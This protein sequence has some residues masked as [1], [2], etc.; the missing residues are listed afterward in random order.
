MFSS[1]KTA[2]P[3]SGYNLTK[4][5]RFRSSASA[6]LSRTLGTATD[7]KKWTFSCWVKGNFSN[8]TAYTHLFGT[9]SGSSDTTSNQLLWTTNGVSNF[10]F[11]LWT[12]NV[13]ITNAAYRDPSA[14]YHVMV[15]M[16]NANANATDRAHIYINGVEPTYSTDNRASLSTSTNYAINSSILHTFARW[17]WNNGTFAQP[18]QF[19][20]YMAE[21]N[22]IDG[23]ALTPS[24]FG[25]T[26]A[27]TGVWQP[28]RYTGTYGTNG[29]YLPFTNTTSTT[30]L[31]YDFSG[32]SNTWTVN[33]ISLT[34]G[35]TYD[36]MTDVPTLTSATA[37]NY[38]T[39]NPLKRGT[40]YNPTISNGNLSYQAENN[41]QNPASSTMGVPSGTYYYEATIVLRGYSPG[42]GACDPSD[43]FGT[44]DNW[45]TYMK[46]VI[47][48]YDGTLYNNGS[49]S[50]T[51]YTFTTGDVMSV[52]FNAT[53]GKIWIAKNG[54]YYNSG[55]PAAGTGQIATATTYANLAP[56]VDGTNN[57]GSKD[58]IAL[59]FGQQPFTYTP[60]TG[61]VALNTY[62]L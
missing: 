38:C 40:T 3:S 2:A 23:Q 14:W 45:R 51:A 41:T 9:G 44:G 24:S 8:G 47:L 27:T 61:F 16:D 28:A 42:I 60:P 50:A 31:G 52:A 1:R 32:N 21:V 7:P 62:N 43:Y 35:S 19:D 11:S 34:A 48:F 59:N 33:N 49:S 26:N 25:S 12:I 39:L 15:V 46:G 22:F 6:Y 55:N 37:A 30:T 18:E 36:S 20:G 29:F 4:S 13:L 53:N 58:Q 54:T 56:I 10:S 57:A 17:S 5:L